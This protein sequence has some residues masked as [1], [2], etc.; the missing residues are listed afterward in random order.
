MSPQARPLT[1]DWG[2]LREGW[3][4]FGN[5]AYIVDVSLMLLLSIILAAVIAYHPSTRRK[6]SNITEFEQP[7]TFLMYAMVGA[8]IAQ[9]VQTYPPMALVIFGI[10]GLL[11]FRTVVGEAKDTGRVILVTVVGLCCGLKIF[12]GAVLATF[13]G[14]IL[15]W[16]LESQNAGRIVVK[17][18]KDSDILTAAETYRGILGEAGC[19]VIRERKNLT[20]GRVTFIV[21]APPELDAEALEEAFENVSAEQRG[22]VDWEIS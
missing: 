11:R 18:L 1:D 16:Y 8:L 10:G 19:T 21:K 20:K 22:V 13:I 7:K 4:N 12:V 15:I 9:L 5:I 17:G 14:W 6:A 2:D 3:E